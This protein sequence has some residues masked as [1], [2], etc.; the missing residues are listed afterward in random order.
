LYNLGIS[1]K[2]SGRNKEA[3]DYF[4]K[5]LEKYPNSPLASDVKKE[6]ASLKA[7]KK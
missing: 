5:L 4:S 6:L 1:Y 7:D 2:E 3:T